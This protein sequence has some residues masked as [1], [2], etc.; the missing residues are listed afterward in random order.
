MKIKQLRQ[1][2]QT[3]S[4]ASTRKG[5]DD[6]AGALSQLAAL[7]AR[8]DTEEVSRFVARVTELRERR[9]SVSV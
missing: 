1:S 7:L 3:A 5:D 4:E 9:K 6:L 8:S 2:L